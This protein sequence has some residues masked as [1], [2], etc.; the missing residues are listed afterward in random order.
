[1]YHNNYHYMILNMCMHVLM[2]NVG[3][4]FI[5]RT[6]FKSLK[7]FDER[8]EFFPTQ[9]KLQR[10]GYEASKAMIFYI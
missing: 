9:N 3:Y 4:D 2:T 10:Q 5:T 6:K 8:H 1:M 7:I